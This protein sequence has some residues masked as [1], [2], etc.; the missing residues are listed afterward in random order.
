MA[1]IDRAS[2]PTILT[3]DHLFSLPPTVTERISTHDFEIGPAQA[4]LDSSEDILFVVPAAHNDFISLNDVRFS[5]DLVVRRHDKTEMAALEDTITPINNIMHSLF[6]SVTLLLNGRLVSDSSELYYMRAYIETLLGYSTQT[7]KSQLSM[8]G[9]YLDED[10]SVPQQGDVRGTDV[11]TRFVY[12]ANKGAMARRQWLFDGQPLQLSG[13]LHL[14]MLQQPKPLIT[15][16]E[17]QI[18]LTRSKTRMVFCADTDEHL[19][20]IA[21][22]NPRL[23][24]RR[25]EPAP[26]FLNSVAKTLLTNNVKY[27]INRVAMRSMTFAAGMQFTTWSNVT[28]GQLPKM[29]IM[30]IVSNTGFSGTHD[31]SPYNFAHFDLA[32]TA[33][34]IEGLTYP[35]RGYEMDFDRGQSVAPYEGLLDCLDRLSEGNGELP[36]DRFGYKKGFSLYGFDFTVARTSMSHLALIKTGNLNFTFR[37]KTPLP[38]AAIVV[39]MLIFDNIIEIT[40]TR[41]VIFDY[42]P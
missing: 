19:P 3:E 39:C 36:F 25:F 37:F 20:I 11:A 31:K 10:L 12:F 29:A 16:V 2:A 24:M 7:Q 35:G 4:V 17:I 30:G 28:M 23:R 15:G 18:R 27:H 13:K 33:A 21:I 41:Q 34:E 6:K 1:L 9:W 8:S 5:C 14:D 32:H 40:N 42:A 26:A 22:R 38:E